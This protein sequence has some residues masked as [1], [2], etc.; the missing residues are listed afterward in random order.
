MIILLLTLLVVGCSSKLVVKPTKE[1]AGTGVI[2]SLPESNLIFSVTRQITKCNTLTEKPS[3]QIEVKV[4]VVNEFKPSSESYVIEYEKLTSGNKTNDLAIQ[5]YD[6][7]ILKSVNSISHDK[8]SEIISDVFSGAANIAVKAATMWDGSA[9]SKACTDETITALDNSSDLKK[10]IKDKQAKAKEYSK[11]LAACEADKECRKP[12]LEKLEGVSEEIGELSKSREEVMK[13]LV[14][15]ENYS[16]TPKKIN[17]NQSGILS[18]SQNQAQK[19]FKDITLSSDIHYTI[20]TESVSQYVSSSKSSDKNY[21]VYRQPQK[22]M[23]L[24]C[25]QECIDE[26]GKPMIIPAERLI[27]KRV[28]IPQLG[29]IGYLPLNNKAFQD[30]TFT[31]TFSRT[32]ALTEFKYIEN[33]Y[34][35]KGA[36][37]FKDVAN[38]FGEFVT[39]KNDLE[40]SQDEAKQKLLEL[41]SQNELNTLEHQLSLLKK[42]KEITD[43]Q[44]DLT[45][46]YTAIDS[47]TE[48]LRKQKEL[49]E[50][51]IEIEKLRTE[52]M[53]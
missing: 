32:G 34:L 23:L 3:V 26:N 31:A 22:V 51:Q 29:Q 9:D 42:E 40:K 1:S 52:Q 27:S 2:Y 4:D 50:L 14:D 36:S 53:N 38:R 11:T 48:K 44:T 28:I 13:A 18:L 37:T 10:G 46:K 12:I 19:W 21:L 5:L 30:K 45:Y 41:N 24:V 33:A 15:I 20:L 7:G 6:D 17:G 49:L 16:I 39:T 25:K 47:E 35:A 43:A 8:T